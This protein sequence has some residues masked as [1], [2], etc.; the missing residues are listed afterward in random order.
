[1]IIIEEVE[2]IDSMENSMT[3]V[4]EVKNEEWG[5][6]NKAIE[7]TSREGAAKL[8]LI[9]ST[10]DAWMIEWLND[11]MIKWLNDWIIE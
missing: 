5:M 11:W 1:V 10:P 7:S 3:K 8:I 6:K 9:T 2:D 4:E